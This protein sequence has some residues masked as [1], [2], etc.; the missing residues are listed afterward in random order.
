MTW[1]CPSEV[2]IDRNRQ[3]IV[4]FDG[5]PSNSTANRRFVTADHRFV[6]AHRRFRLLIVDFDRESSI[7]MIAHHFGMTDHH[8]ASIDHHFGTTDR[9]F[10]L[11]IIDFD[12]ESMIL[13]DS[14]T[15][16][17]NQPSI[18]TVNRR[19]RRTTITLG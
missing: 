10:R 9:R 12:G 14:L 15:K 13:D 3:S 5:E 19:F 6:T 11:L 4:D 18:L 1:V 16:I 8:F 7:S 2:S 17:V